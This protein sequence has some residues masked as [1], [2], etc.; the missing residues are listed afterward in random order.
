MGSMYH[1]RVQIPTPAT[2]EASSAPT[3]WISGR[4]TSCPRSHPEVE[5]S[6]RGSSDVAAQSGPSHSLP[7]PE[8]QPL[9]GTHRVLDSQTAVRDM[10]LDHRIK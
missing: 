9:R 3:G 2:R 4:T 5:R 7:P 10:R 6:P 8:A 1:L